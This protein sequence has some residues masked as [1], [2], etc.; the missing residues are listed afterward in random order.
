MKILF[1]ITISALTIWFM[2]R[3]CAYVVPEPPIGAEKSTYEYLRVLRNNLNKVQITTTNPSNVRLGDY[4]EILI[5][6]NGA[7]FNLMINVSSPNGK[8]W[9]GVVLGV[10]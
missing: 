5:Y 8:T 3:A 7:T 6:K 4:G 9:R 2:G 1:W 10:I